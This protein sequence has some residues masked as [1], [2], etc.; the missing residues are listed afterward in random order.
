MAPP[1]AS[2][3]APA[4]QVEMASTGLVVDESFQNRVMARQPEVV[5]MAP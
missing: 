3:G 1:R 5:R 2:A 4:G